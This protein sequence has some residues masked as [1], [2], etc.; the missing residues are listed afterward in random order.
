VD[1][2]GDIAHPLAQELD[3]PFTTRPIAFPEVVV[4]LGV[5]PGGTATIFTR[6]WT[7]GSTNLP[8]SIETVESFMAI[9]ARKSA[10]NFTFYGMMLIMIP[11]A[12]LAMFF[13]RHPIFPAYVAYASSTL[14]YLMHS[15]GAAFQYL[16]PGFPLFNSFASVVIGASYVTF[17][18]LFA[19]LFLQTP[20][21]HPWIDKIMV[22]LIVV[23]LLMIASTLVVETRI[24]KK[25]LILV[26]FFGVAV[27]TVAGLVAARRRFKRVRFFVF[28]WL[29]ATISAGMMMGRHW[30]GVG[31]SQEFQYDSMRVV[32]IF[33]AVMMGL[34]IVDTYSQLRAER[35]SALQSSL[36]H[37]RRNLDMTARLRELES[38]YELAAQTTA[39]TTGNSP[40]PFTTFASRF[41]PC[42]S[43][44]MGRSAAI[45]KTRRTIPTS[46]TVSTI[47]RRW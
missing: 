36:D 6:Y 44:F 46:M 40:I 8:L 10:K 12:A 20:K 33:D 18:A 29:G 32:M 17:G 47:S 14:L 21:Y 19:R 4:P 5:P 22:A 23:P 30:F 38:R 24:T 28:P 41:M 27:F 3:S 26:A 39:K 34:A 9:S 13:I 37:A 7:E 31:I 25:S 16:W 2:D 43:R 1:A 11:A 35:Q 15:D 45:R 42:G